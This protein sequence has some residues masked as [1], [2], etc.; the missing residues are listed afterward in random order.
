ML[1]YMYPHVLCSELQQLLQLSQFYNFLSV[2]II[3]FLSFY[4]RRRTEPGN[5]T[6]KYNVSADA[7]NDKR[8][9][10]CKD[11]KNRFE[12]IYILCINVVVFLSPPEQKGQKAFAKGWK[13]LLDSYLV[14]R[15][16]K[17]FTLEIMLLQVHYIIVDQNLASLNQKIG[18]GQNCGLLC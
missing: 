11:L 2:T 13:Q 8:I 1:M 4:F 15:A 5:K 6:P 12:V 9:L 7:E 3:S 18:Q 14:R 10:I 16:R 17:C